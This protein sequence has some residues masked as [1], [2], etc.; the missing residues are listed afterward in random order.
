MIVDDAFVDPSGG[1]NSNASVSITVGQTVGWRHAGINPHTVTSTTV[2]GGGMDFDS[3]NL[4]GGETFS[5]T[6]TVAG[7][8]VY[9]CDNHPNVMLGATIIVQ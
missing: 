2:P 8:Y 3:G 7:T 4:D 1:R 9:R 5:V 6:P